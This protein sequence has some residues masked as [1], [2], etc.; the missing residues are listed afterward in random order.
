MRNWFTGK[1]PYAGKDWRQAEKGT[2]ED[3]MDMSLSKLWEL[4]MD[5]EAWRAV[6][7]GVAKNQTQLSDWTEVN[8]MKKS[9]VNTTTN[10]FINKDNKYRENGLFDFQSCQIM[11]CIMSN[12]QYKST[13]IL[14]I[15]RNM[16][17]SHKEG[18]IKN[19]Q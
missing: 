3:K 14:E 19:K 1:D 6:V 17:V 18:K 13:R 5:R 10:N 11:I 12:F 9:S 2:T 15:Q 7:H 8:L 16:H 4:V